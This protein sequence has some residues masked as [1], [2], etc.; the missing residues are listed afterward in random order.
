MRVNRKLLPIKTHY[1]LQYAGSAF[2]IM[3]LP[4]IVRQKGVSAQGIG[5]VFTAMPMVGL[6]VNSFAG[7]LA[8]YFR[9]YKII[10]LASIVSVIYGFT[11]VYYL[12]N[13][14]VSD[15]DHPS[16]LNT[17]GDILETEDIVVKKKRRE[18]HI[19]NIP[20][21][22]GHDVTENEDPIIP[23]IAPELATDKELLRL[24]DLN[25]T[26]DED[27]KPKEEDAHDVGEESPRVFDIYSLVGFPQFWLIFLS[28]T[29]AHL[30]LNLCIMIADSVCF[31]ILDSKR[32]KYGQ[33]RLWGALGMGTMAIIVGAVVDKYSEHLP[34]PDYFP[35]VIFMAIFLTMDFVVVA[36]MDIPYAKDCKVKIG[37][38][39]SV[40]RRPQVISFLVAIYVISTSLGMLWVFKMLMIEDVA[41]KWNPNFKHLKL[42]QGLNL[43]IENFG[44]EMPFFFFSGSIILSLGHT[45]VLSL[46]LASMA[47]RC[48]LY[49]FVSNPWW[50]L[51]IELLNGPSYGL[52]YAVMASYASHV[53]PPGAQATLQAIARA[54]FSMGLSTAGWVG[55]SLYLSLG[56]GGP[57]FLCMGLFNFAFCFIYSALNYGLNRCCP[58]S[59]VAWRGQY[60]VA[61]KTS[62]EM[63]Q[64]KI[65]E[66]ETSVQQALHRFM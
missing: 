27:R 13:I 60:E 41:M 34:T 33:Q 18:T 35:A 12:S 26:E 61:N 40:V 55:G 57:M 32:H 48:C 16:V 8:D 30:G 24:H 43:S 44:G 20:S 10:F 59:D 11:S 17:S 3:V 38:V 62:L 5:I 14:A 6:I 66:D 37:E 47:L 23:R 29:A 63:E 4:L 15:V 9:A 1:F 46:S 64:K 28:V 52:F 21:F 42:L 54:G 49:Y 39:G 31:Q 22:L 36:A 19:P 65:D 53:A 2:M 51:P 56:G 58:A 7:A 25:N 50:F 45:V